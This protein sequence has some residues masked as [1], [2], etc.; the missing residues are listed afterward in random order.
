MPDDTFEQL[1]R[2]VEPPWHLP[3]D[4]ELS[5]EAIPHSATISGMFVAPL[6]AEAKRRGMTL[7]SARDRYLPFGFYP[8]REHARLLVEICTQGFRQLPLRQALRKLGRGA[9]AALMSS[10]LGKVMLGSVESTPDIIVA[11]ARAFPLNARPSRVTVPML[12]RGRA[13]VRME[14]V[15]HFLDCHQVGVFEGA[16]KFAGT[17]GSVLIDVRGPAAADLLLTWDA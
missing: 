11:M 15:H 1:Q 9:P 10:T 13:I 6:I 5:L 8:L 7:P 2:F 17:P 16:L 4:V 3:L 14:E 12:E